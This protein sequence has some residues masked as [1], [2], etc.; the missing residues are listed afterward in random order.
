MKRSGNH[1]ILGWMQQQMKGSVSFLNNLG[2]YYP[3]EKN[4]INHFY[5]R[6]FGKHSLLISMEDWFPEQAFFP[7]DEAKFGKASEKYDVLILRD[8]F[9]MFASR[10]MW[11]D[12]F[13]K[14]FRNDREYRQEVTEKWKDNARTYLKWES[15]QIVSKHQKYIPINYNQWFIDGVYREEL[16]V[17]LNL[18]FSDQGKE[19]VAPYGFGSSFDGVGHHGSASQLKVL[20]RWKLVKDEEAYKNLFEDPEIVELSH[21]IFGILE[22][23]EDWLNTKS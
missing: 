17:Q 1:A 6:G 3:P 4:R 10:W 2:P 11:K 9:N 23:V 16:A 21:S 15:E 14:R 19:K 18:I 13:G 8:P 22:G 12:D 5:W 20:E 7:Y